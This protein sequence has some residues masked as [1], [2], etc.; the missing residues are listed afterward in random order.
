MCANDILCHGARPLFFLDYLACGNLD[1]DVAA[2][3]VAGITDACVEI[4]CTLAGGETAEMPGFYA[5][6]TYDVA[7]F[8]VGLA[9]RENLIDGTKVAPGDTL[10]GLPSNGVHSNGFSLVRALDLDW[11]GEIGGTT[12]REALLRPTELYVR[13][14]LGLADTL[15]VHGIAHITGG[16]LP[17]NLPRMARRP[18]RFEVRT[19]TWDPPPVF[20]VISRAGVSEEEM[21]RTFNMGL[22]MVLAVAPDDAERAI[23]VLSQAGVEARSIGRVTEGDGV[24]ID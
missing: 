16:G 24:C 12:V 22:G 2:Q 1:A 21:F 11:D 5:P 23:E 15:C 6:G 7:G 10:I 18:L 13:P 19:K 17:E 20:D 8:I 14:V 4:G 3:I 9:D